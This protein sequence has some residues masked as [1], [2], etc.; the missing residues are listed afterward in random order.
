MQPNQPIPATE[1]D[2]VHPPTP[3]EEPQPDK[4][5]DLPRPGPDVVVPPGPEVIT[6]PQ[7]QETPA[8][9]SGRVS[10]TL[11]GR[12]PMVDNRWAPTPSAAPDGDHAP[13][14]CLSCSTGE[15]RLSPLALDIR[16]SAPARRTIGRM[17]S[18]EEQ[19]TWAKQ[20]ALIGVGM[21][22]SPTLWRPCAP[23][24]TRIP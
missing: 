11:N 5:P 13:T 8:G 10:P 12:R 2:V 16:A 18:H 17:K 20:R 4:G 24:S 3:I 6:P 14:G 7:P 9:A 19:L 23:T 22:R 15:A 1:P 21:G